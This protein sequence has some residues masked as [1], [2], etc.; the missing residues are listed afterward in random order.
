MRLEFIRFGL[1]TKQRIITGVLQLLGA[2]GILLSFWD[3]R[4]AL[5]SAAGLSLLMFLG[6]TV[7]LRIK[8]DV[9]RASPALIYM[10]LCA[11]LCYEFYKRL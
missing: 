4:L 5:F 6:F 11:I 9:Y 1:S 7:R 2:T 8:D 10:V 3:L